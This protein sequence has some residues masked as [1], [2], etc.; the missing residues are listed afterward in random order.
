VLG[1][2]SGKYLRWTVPSRSTSP[3]RGGLLR[4]L[5]GQGRD[6]DRWQRVPG[7]I[8][9]LWILDVH[10]KQLVIDASRMFHSIQFLS[11][12]SRQTASAAF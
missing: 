9:R 12:S 11:V 4:E 3:L 2:F 5:D 6:E 7:Q 8:D 1:R 10:G